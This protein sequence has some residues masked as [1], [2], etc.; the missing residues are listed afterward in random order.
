MVQI[1]ILKMKTRAFLLLLLAV[2]SLETFSQD[3][4]KFNLYRPEENAENAIA[5]A[6]KE[7]KEQKKHVFVQV[8]GNWCIW[9]ARF[10]EY[11]TKDLSID[12]LIQKN[13][14]V[15]HLNYSKENY[16]TDLMAK[17]RFPQR[18][19]FPVFLVLDGEG[20]LLHTQNSEYLEDGKGYDKRK[21]IDFFGNW[22]PKAFDPVNYKE[23]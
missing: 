23:Q 3:L 12:S 7:A 13:Y 6:L 1:K 18:F 20:S 2:F 16:N 10:N 15:Y 22:S 14:V 8:G 17:Y 19:G 9:C 11:V 5:A 4:A 21:V